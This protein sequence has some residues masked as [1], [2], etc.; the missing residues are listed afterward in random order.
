MRDRPRVSQHGGVVEG[1]S[2]LSILLV[3]ISCVLEQKLTG[4]QRALKLNINATCYITFHWQNIQVIVFI[5][6]VIINSRSVVG[7]YL[8]ETS[9]QL[10]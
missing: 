9:F 1:P 3:H 2:A 8:A 4:D 7:N 6:S 10:V 5:Y